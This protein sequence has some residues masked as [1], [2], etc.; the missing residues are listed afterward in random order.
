MTGVKIKWSMY[1]KVV[2]HNVQLDKI[3]ITGA[4]ELTAPKKTD[5][6]PFSPDKFH[7]IMAGI[8]QLTLPAAI[9]ISQFDYLPSISASL[10]TCLLILLYLLKRP[11]NITAKSAPQMAVFYGR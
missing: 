1:P 3:I 6:Q 11:S 10:I 5:D 7:Q 9:N 4:D 2:V 8:A